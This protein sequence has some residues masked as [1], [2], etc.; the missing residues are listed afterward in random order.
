MN[1]IRSRFAVTM[2]Y[3]ALVCAAWLLS[4]TCTMASPIT[5]GTF[6]VLN[7]TSDPLFTGPT[8]L[9]TNDSSLAGMPATFG[10]L[11]LVFDLLDSSTQSFSLIDFLDPA[12]TIDSNGLVD[13]LGASLLPDLSTVL[14]AHL[15]LTLLDPVTH[16]V[17]AGTLSLGP[18]DPSACDGCTNRM[19]D[20]KD[21][22][23]LAIQFDQTTPVPE[24]ATLILVGGSLGAWAAVRRRRTA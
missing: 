13:G 15:T 4:A 17:L 7:D 11:H 2:K 10:G 9:V 3:S 5:I 14:D 23:T 1:A 16:A 19:V 6:E 21:Q 12:G 8:F 18:L 20:F 22:S 24:P